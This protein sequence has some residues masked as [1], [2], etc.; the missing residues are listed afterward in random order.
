VATVAVIG[1][2]AIGAYC[3]GRLALA[4]HDVR[5]LVRSDLAAWRAGGLRVF[6]QASFQQSHPHG[7]SAAEKGEHY[8]EVCLLALSSAHQST[9]SDKRKH[10]CPNLWISDWPSHLPNNSNHQQKILL[11]A[12]I[13]PSNRTMAAYPSTTFPSSTFTSNA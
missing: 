8:H 7:V 1:S 10:S 9:L 2:G 13:W 12:P 4:G 11:I 6:S 5:F 3:G